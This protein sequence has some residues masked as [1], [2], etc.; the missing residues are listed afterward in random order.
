M[1]KQRRTRAALTVAASMLAIPGFALAAAPAQAADAGG[2]AQ[3]GSHGKV[4]AKTSLNVRELRTTASR[5]VGSLARG[6][7][8]DIGCQAK[9]EP[10][11]DSTKWYRLGPKRWVTAEYVSLTGPAPERCDGS[12]PTGKVIADPS[13]TM[14]EGPSTKTAA[15]G[16]LAH[17]KKVEL[18]CKVNG[19]VVGKNPRWYQLFNGNWVAARYVANLDWTPPACRSGSAVQSVTPDSV[20]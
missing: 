10:I 5:P 18:L 14:R 3:S 9:G 13:L 11:G 1:S 6:T 15:R 2:A 20:G 4:T 16:T 8:V 17:G 12:E 19:E 7:T